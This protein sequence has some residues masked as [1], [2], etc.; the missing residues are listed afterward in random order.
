VVGRLTKGKAEKLICE[1]LSRLM[2]LHMGKGPEVIKC[3]IVKDCVLVRKQGIL[4]PSEQILARSEQGSQ[5]IKEARQEIMGLV[6]NEF[7]DVITRTLGCR[8]LSLHTDIDVRRDER[9]EV[10]ILDKAVG[11]EE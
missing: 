8:V 1:E 5:L 7:E 10:F 9:V 3:N 2:K 6:R 4:T 11:F